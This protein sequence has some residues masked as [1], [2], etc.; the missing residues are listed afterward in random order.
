MDLTLVGIV[1]NAEVRFPLITGTHLVGR[2]DTAALVIA[3]SNISRNHAE[4]IVSEDEVK[5]RDLGFGRLASEAGGAF[6][7]ELP[8][9]GEDLDERTDVFAF[10]LL[11][12]EMLVGERPEGEAEPPSA[13]RSGL[14]PAL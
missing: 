3:H 10:G 7:A 2:S 6:A 9:T 4:I 14:D 11:L 12:Y 13:V 1:N 8:E 5:V